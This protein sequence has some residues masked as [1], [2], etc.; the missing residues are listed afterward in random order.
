MEIRE[1][2]QTDIEKIKDLLI[3]LQQHVIKIDKYNLNIISEEYRDKYF[4]YMVED[5]SKQQ[6][7]IFVATDHNKILGFI[8]GFIQTYDDRDKI[9]YSCPKKG[10]IAELIVSSS[11]RS[12]GTGHNL[13]SAME[14]YFKS[15]GCEYIQIDVFAYNDIA[16]NFYHKHNYEERMITLFKDIK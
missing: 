13:L 3:E 12:K 5:C 10:I 7:K 15:I 2:T 11:S 8:A 9:D 4:D 6:G 1:F 16:K 14:N